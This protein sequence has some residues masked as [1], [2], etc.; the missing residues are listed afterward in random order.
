MTMPD[1]RDI[2]PQRELLTSVYE[3]FNR[4]DIDRILPAMDPAVEWPNGMEGGWVYGRDGVRSYWTRQWGMID[5]RVIPVRF[6]VDELGRIVVDVH[7]TIRSLA[8][9]VLVDRIVQH[10]YVIREG[11][12]ARMEIR[13]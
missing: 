4:R 9:E 10:V 3:A 7:Q 11:M 8:G 13:E 6:E 12:I 5:P 2:T 1:A